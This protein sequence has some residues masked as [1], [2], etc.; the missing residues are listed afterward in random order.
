MFRIA[1]RQLVSPKVSD[2]CNEV[3]TLIGNVPTSKFFPLPAPQRPTTK[4]NASKPIIVVAGSIISESPIVTVS[5]ECSFITVSRLF[6]AASTF[7]T[8]PGKADEKI[9]EIICMTFGL[10]PILRS[11]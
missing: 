8:D 6:V 10:S 2:A 1:F 4:F 9:C 3:I 11:S 5:S 7:S